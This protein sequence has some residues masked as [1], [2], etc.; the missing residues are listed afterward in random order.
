MKSVRAKLHDLTGRRRWAGL[1][2][3]RDVIAEINPILRGWGNYFRTGNATGKFQAVDR[4]V[5]E[6]LLRLLTRRGGQRRPD[7]RRLRRTQWPHRRFVDEHG[8]YQLLGTICYPG[9]RACRT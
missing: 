4:Y 2:D 6:R 8:L 9:G 3:I 1:K 5:R 7:A